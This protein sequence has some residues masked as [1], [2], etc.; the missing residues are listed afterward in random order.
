LGAPAASAATKATQSAASL[1][2]ISRPV[3]F[4]PA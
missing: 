4:A 3:V 2:D 1:Q